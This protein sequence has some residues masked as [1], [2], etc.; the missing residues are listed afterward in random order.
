MPKLLLTALLACTALPALAQAPATTPAPVVV[1]ADR[2]S[3][4]PAGVV[5]IAPKA[6]TLRAAARL[7]ELR[8]PEGDMAMAIVD[9]GAAADARAAIDAA[10]RA[11]APG[12]PRTP[13]LVSAL[14][15]KEGWEERQYADYE[16]SPNERRLTVALALR[17]GTAWT[18]LL[19]DGAEQT[20]EKR[21]AAAALVR[22]SIR[23]AGYA[24]ESFAGRAAHP[25]TPERIAALRSFLAES[26]SAMDI[27]GAAVALTDRK[28]TLFAGGVGVRE[29]GRPE[30]VDGDTQFMI[31][32]NTK[33]MATLLL[34]K[35]VDEGKLRWDQP[36]T[37]VYP[38]FKLG[39]PET[40]AKVLVRHLV[41]AC[42]GLPRKDM[43]WLLNTRPD[44]PAADTFV[45]LAATQPTSGFGEVFQYNNL[46]ASAAGYI[47][48]H[49]AHP[50]MELG[51]AFDLA[52]REKIFVPLG[53]TATGFDS[54]A[55]MRGNWARPHAFDI[56]GRTV[57]SV[58]EGM[59]LNEAVMPFRPAGGA[60]SSAAD[61][62]K[63]VR[64]E[65]N[66]GRLDD[67]RQWI[68]AANLLERRKP[69]VL[70]GEDE[71]YGMGLEQGEIGGVK[72]IH[73]GGSL[74]GYKTDILFV[75]EAGVGAVILTNADQGRAL[76]AAF[77]RRLLE[78]MYDGKPEAAATVAATA[79]RYKAEN[80]R[81]RELVTVPA[82]PA[83]VAALAPTYTNAELGR[84]EVV[85]GTTP[86]FRFTSFDTPVA[87][88][89][90]P[91]GTTSFV[92]LEPTVLGF[93]L[94]MANGG[95]QLIV[96][97]GQHEYRFEAV[98]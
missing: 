8:A 24:R 31:A 18:V 13:K 1:D 47:G 54:A 82:D 34:A 25:M 58:S 33:G 29:L 88:R 16:V 28:R 69:G 20:F 63:Y 43:Q 32:S 11:Y 70:S 65:L 67:G 80:A 17:R 56:D 40:T 77:Q 79:A 66:Q 86:V 94:V 74:G 48:G 78:I 35:L 4:T 73:H 96:R 57:A 68:T 59:R 93:P 98:R 27:P 51:R 46:M 91:D 5:F 64:F 44:T 50:D 55:A 97:D 53:M 71:Y 81:E 37:Q 2:A 39:S 95:K 89:R 84:I 90:N 3:S 41:C 6:W 15:P 7:A 23:P 49:L 52:M 76:L 10:W 38:A 9:V 36:V 83:A 62:I 61:L 85:K 22:D 30:P 12:A 45:Q 14:A 75:P 19:G 87:T 26:I 72:V 60:W 92:T 21:G 42:T